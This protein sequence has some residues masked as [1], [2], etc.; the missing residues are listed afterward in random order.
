MEN[1]K[2]TNHSN[3]HSR[4][5]WN[6]FQSGE[7]SRSVKGLA[8]TTGNY[9]EALHDLDERYGNI[10]ITVSSHFEELTSYK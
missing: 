1:Q 3:M 7:A 5:I 8:V 9:E 4:S 10:Q 6:P 2:S